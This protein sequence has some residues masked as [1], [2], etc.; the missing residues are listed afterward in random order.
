MGKNVI[1]I[2][3]VSIQNFTIGLEFN[4]VELTPNLN[5][6]AKEGM[7]FSNFYAQES[8]GT[9]SDSEFTLSTSLLPTSNGTVFINY[10]DREYLTIQKYI[11]IFCA[12]RN[13]FLFFI[14]NKNWTSTIFYFIT[15]YGGTVISFPI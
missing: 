4:G 8:V 7:F 5:K 1:V 14:C 15:I 13:I 11:F 2:H 12:T 6:L 3:A 10:W 9:S